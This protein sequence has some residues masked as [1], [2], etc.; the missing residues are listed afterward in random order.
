MLLICCGVGFG[1]CRKIFFREFSMR[2]FL[3]VRFR[4]RVCCRIVFMLYKFRRFSVFIFFS[5]I[6]SSG[7]SFY[8]LARLRCWVS[9]RQ[10]VV[11]LRIFLKRGFT[12][13]L[14]SVCEYLRVIFFCFSFLVSCVIFFLMVETFF[15]SVNFGM[16]RRTMYGSGKA[17]SEGFGNQVFVLLVV[18]WGSQGV[19]LFRNLYSRVFRGIFY[20]LGFGQIFGSIFG[21][22]ISLLG[23]VWEFNEMGGLVRFCYCL[24]V[25]RSLRVCDWLWGKIIFQRE[26]GVWQE[27]I[28]FEVFNSYQFCFRVSFFSGRRQRC[29]REKLRLWVC[30]GGGGEIWQIQW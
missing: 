2:V 4:F 23:V 22:I 1:Y 5:Y 11:W 6:F 10:M 14:T 7:S 25:G 17:V 28:V 3:F 19:I 18:S 27:L 12:A 8:M 26:Q 16:Q 29:R 9:K 13:N 15:G 24:V 30:I 21:Q 20:I